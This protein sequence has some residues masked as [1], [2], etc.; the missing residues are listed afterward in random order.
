M[1]TNTLSRRG[2]LASAAAV[3]AGF[4]GLRAAAEAVPAEA[5][6]AGVGY[7]PLM[8]DPAGLIK[9]PKGFSY[10]VLSK[11]GDEMDDGL[12]VP[13]M[14]DGMAAFEGPGN[15]TVLVCNHEIDDDPTS[16]GA[17][18][19]ANERVGKIAAEKL[20]DPG[21]GTTGPSLGGCTRVIVDNASGEV[22]GKHLALAGTV[23]NCAGGPTPWGTWVTCEEDVRT[24]QRDGFSMSHGYNFEVPSAPTAGVADPLPI[25][26][27]GRFNHEAI[28]VDPRTG[29][30][31][32][33]EDRHE[34]LIYRYLPNTPGKLHDGGRLQALAI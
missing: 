10:R 19:E 21:D 7:G 28:A 5:T 13:G 1:D 20:Y 34:G 18:G 8:D 24:A 16:I 22:V 12:L 30:V 26:A 33:T 15:T 2:F 17:F 9:L 3:S 4:M 29:A 6:S 23:R 25:K 31:Y 32:Q 14:Q 11:T 27:M